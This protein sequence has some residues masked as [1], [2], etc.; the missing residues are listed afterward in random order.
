MGLWVTFVCDAANKRYTAETPGSVQLKN[1][2]NFG[3]AIKRELI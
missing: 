3:L 2:L 1:K